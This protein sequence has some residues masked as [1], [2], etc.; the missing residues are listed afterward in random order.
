MQI[1]DLVYVRCCTLPNGRVHSAIGIIRSI[2]DR[3][4][5]KVYEVWFPDLGHGM[6][7]VKEELILLEEHDEKR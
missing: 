5:F 3:S 6:S 7:F 1:G 2:S 4:V